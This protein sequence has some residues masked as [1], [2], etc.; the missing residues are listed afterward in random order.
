MSYKNAE[1]TKKANVYHG[2][3]VTSRS[4]V[5]EAGESKTLG[6]MLPGSYHFGTGLPEVM[7]VTAGI[8]R[9]KLQ[10]EQDWQEYVAGES[11]SIPGDSSFDIEVVELLDYVCHF[12]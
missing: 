1:I 10:G 12:G 8:C 6:V 2:G 11:F 4:I 9:V 3:K 5:T 7:E